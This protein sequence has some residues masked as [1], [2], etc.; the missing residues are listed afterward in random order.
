MAAAEDVQAELLAAVAVALDQQGGA[1]LLAGRGADPGLDR[2]VD[3]GA[4]GG[5]VNVRDARGALVALEATLSLATP[6]VPK[7]VAVF[8][9]AGLKPGTALTTFE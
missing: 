7:V 5:E 9:F 1:A 2:E 6:F 4:L 3:V 8:G